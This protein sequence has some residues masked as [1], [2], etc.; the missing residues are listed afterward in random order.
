MGSHPIENLMTNAMNSI[1][2]MVDVNTIIGDAIQVGNG[3][4]IIPLSKV[5]FGFASGG[6]EFSTKI[7]EC[8]KDKLNEEEKLPFGGGSGAGVTINPVSFLVVQNDTVKLMPVTHKGNVDKLLDY[9][10][11]IMEKADTI[12]TKIIDKKADNTQC[13]MKYNKEFKTKKEED[14]TTNQEEIFEEP[15]DTEFEYNYKEIYEDE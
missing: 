9:I 4:V 1:K 14:K 13:K 6:T 12:L 7:K 10:P 3:T 15:A 11:D 2:D 5:T 8:R